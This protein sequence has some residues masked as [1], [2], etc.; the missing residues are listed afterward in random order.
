VAVGYSMGGPIA[1]LLW[2]HHWDRIS[3]LVLCATAMEFSDADRRRKA[4]AVHPLLN[5]VGRVA[6]RRFI[7]RVARKYLSNSIENPSLRERVMPE[8]GR[9]DP[10]TVWQAAP[11]VLRF[12]SSSWLGDVDVPTS[13]VLT[14]L[15]GV[16]PPENQRALANKIPGAVVHRVSSDHAVCVRQLELFVPALKAA[17]KYVVDRI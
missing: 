14:E 16:V 13:V 12:D 10:I 1:Q 6:P 5:A 4:S 3:G 7:Q 8:V 11:A 17:C 2:R 9:S 15:D